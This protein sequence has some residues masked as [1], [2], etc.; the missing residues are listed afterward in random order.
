MQSGDAK[1]RRKQYREDLDQLAIELSG[2]LNRFQRSELLQV[3]AKNLLRSFFYANLVINFFDNLT[4][5]TVREMQLPK[6][7]IG[8]IKNSY[9]ST[10]A[11][12]RSALAMRGKH[13]SEDEY[14]EFR[15]ELAN[16]YP[17]FIELLKRIE[18]VA[19]LKR[20]NAY[21]R[22]KAREFDQAGAE[23]NDL[24]NALETEILAVSIQKVNRLPSAKETAALVRKLFTPDRLGKLARPLIDDIHQAAE[25]KLDDE[26]SNRNAFEARLYGVWGE[27]LD[28]LACL[29]EVAAKAGERKAKALAESAS[30]GASY[31]SSALVQIHARSIQIGN[32]ILSLLRSGFAD[33]ANSRW[34]SLY[35]LAVVYL[36]LHAQPEELSKRFLAHDDIERFKEAREYQRA[37]RKLGYPPFGRKEFRILKRQYDALVGNYSPGFKRQYG[38]VPPSSIW[39]AKAPSRG[40]V[41]FRNIEER[42]NLGKWRPF[43]SLASNAVHAGPR[44]FDRLGLIRQDEVLLT[45]ASN[46]G[47]A[48][49][50]VN[51][52]I[53]VAQVSTALLSLESDLEDFLAAEAISI[54][55]R[56]IDDS[57]V[58]VQKGIERR[59]SGL[60]SEE[61]GT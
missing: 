19:D 27:P 4:A 56:R 1:A 55:S 31:K 54:Y 44:G 20:A 38:W 52:G 43:Y 40:R 7:Q 53:S 57:A 32:E 61:E 34:R 24:L 36:F 33:G 59:D 50:L 21:F 14:R 17:E 41:T 35:E 18:D 23:N 11:A 49:P 47:L 51:T 42:V 15:R 13:F 9:R 60:D 8:N 39:D 45:G 26:S 46:Y 29:I 16:D 30:F 37:Y 12:A 48:D 6:G 2:F 10:T 28:L 25:D 22:Q 5:K 3:Y 58:R